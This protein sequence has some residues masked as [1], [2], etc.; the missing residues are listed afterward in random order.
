MVCIASCQLQVTSV[1]D[2]E[3]IYHI[4]AVQCLALLRKT[5]CWCVDQLLTVTFELWKKRGTLVYAARRMQR[6]RTFI[7]WKGRGWKPV[8][9]D[10]DSPTLQQIWSRGGLRA[11]SVEI[12]KTHDVW[13]DAQA[14]CTGS[15]SSILP[16]TRAAFGHQGSGQL[17]PWPG[18]PV[19]VGAK[20]QTWSWK[21][22][23]M[24]EKNWLCGS[25]GF[26]L[27]APNNPRCIFFLSNAWNRHEKC[28]MFKFS[29][30]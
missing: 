13:P 26:G 1:L 28:K 19:S 15:T 18:Y 12:G 29:G 21:T 8:N 11:G 14:T 5:N 10:V 23:F 3:H 22:K 17:Q 24:P 7:G 16:W 4:W 27:G 20:T 9:E 30:L 25:C 6:S 2:N